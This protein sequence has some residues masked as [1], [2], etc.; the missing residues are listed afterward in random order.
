MDDSVRL[1]ASILPLPQPYTVFWKRFVAATDESDPVETARRQLLAAGSL[2]LAAPFP[3]VYIDPLRRGF[4]YVF[5]IASPQ[6]QPQLLEQ[7]SFENLIGR[8]FLVSM[9]AATH[10]NIAYSGLWRSVHLFRHLSLRLGNVL[11]SYLYRELLGSDHI[12]RINQ[13]IPPLSGRRSGEN[14]ALSLRSQFR[15]FSRFASKRRIP[16]G[17][18]PHYE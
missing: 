16:A 15:T 7:L 14:R 4:L 2:D 10:P 17:T 11:E 5:R 13:H 1:L 12:A 9:V 8:S 18:D 3:R 6:D